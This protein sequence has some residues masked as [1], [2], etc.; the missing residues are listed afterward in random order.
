MQLFILKIAKKNIIKKFFF[1]LI[2][3]KKTFTT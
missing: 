3:T 1:I 2:F